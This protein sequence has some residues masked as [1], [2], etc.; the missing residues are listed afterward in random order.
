[1]HGHPGEA[2]LEVRGTGNEAPTVTMMDILDM[3]EITNVVTV[4]GIL[5]GIFFG[6][7]QLKD[8]VKSRNTDLFVDLYNQLT[9]REF[10]RMYNDVVYKYTWRDYDDWLSKYG[11]DSNQ[12]A[13]ADFNSVGYFFDGI[14]VLVYRNLI[15]IQLVDD[16]MSSAVIWLWEKVGP[17]VKERRIKRNRPQIWEWVEYLYYKIQENDGVEVE[18]GVAEKLSLKVKAGPTQIVRKA[19]DWGILD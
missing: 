4:L 19:V 7:R 1:V 5:I 13:W 2:P 14:G 3:G 11:P 16:L 17:I 8:I 6:L 15:D 12:E 18:S 9:S 10:Q